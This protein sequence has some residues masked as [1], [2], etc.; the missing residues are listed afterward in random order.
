MFRNLI[1][2]L[3]ILALVWVVRGMI[4]KNQL[5]R[6]DTDAK[7]GKDMVRC[8]HCGT[9]LPKDD[10]VSNGTQYFCGSRHLEAWKRD[11]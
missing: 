5:K 10:A 9:Y 8:A 7:I 2:I 11:H 4:R 1:I 6:P 3:A